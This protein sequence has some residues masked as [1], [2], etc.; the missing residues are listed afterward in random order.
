MI[1]VIGYTDCY[2]KGRQNQIYRGLCEE[3]MV[4]LFF[5]LR[6]F[7]K[8]SSVEMKNSITESERGEKYVWFRK[9]IW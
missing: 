4:W 5:C 2:C 3:L 6:K 8:G 9:I 1:F 7:I